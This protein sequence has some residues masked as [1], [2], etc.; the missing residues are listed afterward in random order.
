MNFLFSTR[1]LI[2]SPQ[3]KFIPSVPSEGGFLL[4]LYNLISSRLVLLS[5]PTYTLFCLEVSFGFRPREKGHTLSLRMVFLRKEGHNPHRIENEIH[6]IKRKTT[7]FI[8][9]REWQEGETGVSVETFRGTIIV[10]PITLLIYVF[11]LTSYYIVYNF[12]KVN[13][14]GKPVGCRGDY[15]K[16]VPL[17]RK[18][19]QR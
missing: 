4:W 2:V 10:G 6:T 13:K 5:Q 15:Y 9:H 7:G 8:R 12:K 19:L 1:S 3:M 17:R 18:I 11:K 16:V 14:M